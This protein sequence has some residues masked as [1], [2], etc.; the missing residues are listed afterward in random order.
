MMPEEMRTS[1]VRLSYLAPKVLGES[2]CRVGGGGGLGK[3]W[4]KQWK[5]LHY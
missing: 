1:P 2:T 4:K 5:P 3:G